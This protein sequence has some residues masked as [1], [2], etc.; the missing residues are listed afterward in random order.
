M[1]LWS[2]EAPA[3]HKLETQEGQCCFD[4][5][6]EAWEPRGSMGLIPVQAGE[7]GFP[8]FSVQV[9]IKRCEFLL[10]CLFWLRP[11]TGLDDAHTHWGRWPALSRPPIQMLI[12]PRHSLTETPRKHASS[13]SCGTV[14]L[15][16]DIT[17]HSDWVAVAGTPACISSPALSSEDRDPE[18]ARGPGWG[19][20]PRNSVIK[21]SNTLMQYF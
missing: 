15:T 10:L 20:L 11:S 7:D 12:L 5:S 17:H 21:T 2:W 3:I 9:G 1:R 14:K 4:P 16:Q 8:C 19:E 18:A 6:P 13:G